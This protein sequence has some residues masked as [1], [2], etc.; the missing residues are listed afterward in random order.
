M[1]AKTC[2]DAFGKMGILVDGANLDLVQQKVQNNFDS[3]RVKVKLEK[4]L[5]INSLNNHTS[6]NE[7]KDPSSKPTN[8]FNPY[9]RLFRLRF[10]NLPSEKPS[11]ISSRLPSLLPS[12]TPSSLPSLILSIV[13]SLVPSNL[14]LVTPTVS[15]S[16]FPRCHLFSAIYV[17][18]LLSLFPFSSPSVLTFG[19]SIC[20]SIRGTI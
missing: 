14:P 16:L 12:R 19:Y 17:D 6:S 18:S 20:N 3:G 11:D 9:L 1:N 2:V 15:T 10:H 8:S 5:N 7:V 13:P 4:N